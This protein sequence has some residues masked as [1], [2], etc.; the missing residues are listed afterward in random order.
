MKH[1]ACFCAREDRESSF[2]PCEPPPSLFK[3]QE[4]SKRQFSP[5]WRPCEARASLFKCGRSLKMLF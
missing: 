5:L 2:H 3:C 1:E 4:I